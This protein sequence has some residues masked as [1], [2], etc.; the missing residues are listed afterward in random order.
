MDKYREVK[1]YGGE[2]K[3]VITEIN[4]FE[5]KGMTEF[6]LNDCWCCYLHLSPEQIPDRK[7][8][9]SIWLDPIYDDKDR[10]SYDHYNG[11]LGNLGWHGGITFYRKTSCVDDKKRH[12]KVGCDYQ[13]Y[14]D[15][16]R[17]YDFDWLKRDV[18]RVAQ[19]FLDIVPDY[20]RHCGTV[21]GYWLPSEGV[22]SEDQH[23]FISNKGIDWMNKE[24]PNSK[25]WWK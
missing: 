14:G 17:G 19:E 11:L 5:M 25:G 15:E 21:G 7:L 8:A 2:Y 12:V 4:N 1:R 24:Y 23:S 13:H 16:G 9:E 22:L 18:E 10:V 6:G 3:G 20:K